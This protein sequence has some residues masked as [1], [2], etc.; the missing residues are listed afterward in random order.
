[1]RSLLLLSALCA[2]ESLSLV[3]APSRRHAVRQ[4][5]AASTVGTAARWA[6]AADTPEAATQAAAKLSRNAIEGKLSKVP[7]CALVNPEDAPYLSGG[8]VGYFY[9]DPP[10]ER[11]SLPTGRC[12]ST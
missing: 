8:R 4:L 10:A 5:V 9:L 6:T 3:T 12:S 2:I 1:M 11:S 7:V